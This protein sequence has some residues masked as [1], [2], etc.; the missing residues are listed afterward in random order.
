MNTPEKLVSTKQPIPFSEI[1]AYM[2][3][4]GFTYTEVENSH[5]LFILPETSLKIVMPLLAPTDEIPSHF[6]AYL[7]RS[8]IDHDILSNTDVNIPVGL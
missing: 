1:K 3:E 2:K 4:L 7:K 6:R 8:L 5:G